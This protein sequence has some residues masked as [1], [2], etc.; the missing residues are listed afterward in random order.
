MS[1]EKAY[2]TRTRIM[3]IMRALIERPYGYTIQQLAERYGVHPDTIR[4]DFEAFQNADFVI[5]RDSRNRY[6]FVED[7]PYKQLKELLHFSEEDQALLDGAIDQ[8]SG[9]SAQAERLKKKLAALYDFRRLGHA[10]LRKPYLTKIDLLNEACEKKLRVILRDYRS[11]NSNT[12][13]DRLVEPFHASPAEDILHAFDVQSMKIRHYRISRFIRV[14]VTHDPWEYEK[15]HIVMPTDPFRIVDAKQVNVHLR[16][17][18]GAYNALV[19]HFPVTKAYIEESSEPNVYDLQCMVNHQ[20]LGLS[21]FILGHYHQ[22]IEVIEPEAL[23]TL[24]NNEVK[25]MRF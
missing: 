12:V 6:A 25:K 4:G 8:L 24:L 16:M 7:K 10:Y 21:N 13:S 19:E 14:Q 18:V 15:R 17:L 3:R 11:S 2:S 23:I 9:R 5:D 20:F 1:A 22:V